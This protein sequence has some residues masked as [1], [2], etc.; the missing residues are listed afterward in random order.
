MPE[1]P[2]ARERRLARNRARNK[3]PEFKA[4]QREY[5]KNVSAFGSTS[6]I[7][8]QSLGDGIANATPSL[9]RR[10]NAKG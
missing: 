5:K 2:G 8:L 3:T 4:Q 6:I 10:D 1:S 9:D 7:G